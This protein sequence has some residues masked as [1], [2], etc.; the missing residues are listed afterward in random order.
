MHLSICRSREIYRAWVEWGERRNTSS[1][2]NP[3]RSSPYILQTDTLL[4]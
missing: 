1:P 2:Y 3:T 4:Y